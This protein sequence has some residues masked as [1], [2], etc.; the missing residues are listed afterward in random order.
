MIGD[1]RQC[2]VKTSIL[3]GD[4]R[5][6]FVKTSIFIGDNRQCSTKTSILIGDNRQCSTKTRILGTKIFDFASQPPTARRII[7]RRR[8]VRV[9]SHR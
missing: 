7:P 8:A 3:I 4:N 9:Y 6:S 5:R 2:F 1:N